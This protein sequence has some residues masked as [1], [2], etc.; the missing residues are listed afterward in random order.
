ML[1]LPVK[2]TAGAGVTP[3]DMLLRYSCC[4][5]LLRSPLPSR[6]RRPRQRPPRMPTWQRLPLLLP[7]PLLPPAASPLP[8]LLP[9]LWSARRRSWPRCA[10]MTTTLMMRLQS[11]RARTRSSLPALQQQQTPVSSPLQQRRRTQTPTTSRHPAAT[12]PAAT[13]RQQRPA[14]PQVRNSNQLLGPGM[15]WAVLRVVQ[16]GMSAAHACD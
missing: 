5:P 10:W 11:R 15:T 13:S 9:L 16:A 1:A 12:S 6:P 14:S 3:T 2:I 7:L 8:Q 4:R